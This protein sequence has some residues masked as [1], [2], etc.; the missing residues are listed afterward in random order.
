[1]FQFDKKYRKMSFQVEIKNLLIQPALNEKS[2]AFVKSNHSSIQTYL[3]YS[4]GDHGD[5]I[6]SMGRFKTLSNI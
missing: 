1:M 3:Y 5:I 6:L 4:E 2:F